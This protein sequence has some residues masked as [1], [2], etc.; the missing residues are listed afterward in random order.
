M[1]AVTVGPNIMSRFFDKRQKSSEQS[2]TID[3]ALGL[4]LPAGM[5]RDWQR[6]PEER[7]KLHNLIASNPLQCSL[8]VMDA[9]QFEDYYKGVFEERVFIR[10]MASAEE[11]HFGWVL[12]EPLHSTDPS[13]LKWRKWD[14]S[15][16]VFFD[17]FHRQDA[18]APVENPDDEV[19]PHRRW[20]PHTLA[21]LRILRDKFMD[22]DSDKVIKAVL[23][24]ALKTKLKNAAG[25]TLML[26]VIACSVAAAI[27]TGTG[28]ITLSVAMAQGIVSGAVSGTGSLLGG[29]IVE[30][31]SGA[32]PVGGWV[33]QPMPPLEES[34]TP[35]ALLQARID[36]LEHAMFETQDKNAV[37]K[38]GNAVARALRSVR[39][40]MKT[41]P[42]T[43][44]LVTT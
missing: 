30:R 24:E 20:S 25:G 40:G 39:G 14:P 1:S 5:L 3:G 16:A 12:L 29:S 8:V 34:L 43:P 32:K 36:R 17:E 26:G 13:A 42:R 7:A 9:A 21:M 27:C 22:P 31:A 35:M 18:S 11:V 4:L 37:Q 15:S 23:V 19:S 33:K 2:R 44:L 28:A 6:H 41:S 10:A 38:A